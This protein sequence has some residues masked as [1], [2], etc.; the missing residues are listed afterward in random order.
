MVDDNINKKND[1]DIDLVSDFP[2]FLRGDES[3]HDDADI[4]HFLNEDD[5]TDPLSIDVSSNLSK[6]NDPAEFDF[7]TLPEPGGI[8]DEPWFNDDLSQKNAT[9]GDIE[10]ISNADSQPELLSAQPN[11]K[12]ELDPD[13][14]LSYEIP[15]VTSAPGK[16]RLGEAKEDE[17]LKS[18]KATPAEDN[19]AIPAAADEE[20]ALQN[21]SEDNVVGSQPELAGTEDQPWFNDHLSKENATDGDIEAISEPENEVSEALL[22]VES[23][24]S[25]P[26]EAPSELAEKQRMS[27]FKKYSGSRSDKYFE[28]SASDGSAD[29]T[30]NNEIDSIHINIGKSAYGWNV[31]FD[32]GINMNLADL[33]EYQIR[34]GKL[35]YPDGTIVHG[36]SKL[37]FS[38]IE[39]IVV[40]Q[41]PEYYH[42]GV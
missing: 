42:Y 2:S 8:E 16:P 3:G 30:G 21:W 23:Q 40:Y 35:P 28:F 19:E 18:E 36:M 5:L 9:D 20:S 7:T 37:R 11:E 32:N 15:D 38:R 24:K 12:K 29:F 39:R 1:S 13:D 4:D 41:A 34:N 17:W 27:M 25:L 26:Q 14:Y 10:A 22:S 6:D 31:S 33:K